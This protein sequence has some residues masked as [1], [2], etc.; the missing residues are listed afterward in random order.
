MLDYKK[1]VIMYG[2]VMGFFYKREYRF[3]GSVKWG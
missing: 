1:G 3:R 2:R